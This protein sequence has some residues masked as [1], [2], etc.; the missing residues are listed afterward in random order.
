LPLSSSFE[1]DYGAAVSA[2]CATRSASFQMVVM[3][4]GLRVAIEAAG[5]AGDVSGSAPTGRCLWAG[6][7][8]QALVFHSIRAAGCVRVAEVD[9][10][11]GGDGEDC[12]AG[13]SFP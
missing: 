4:Q 11:A 5:N 3:I 7:G 1:P 10:N 8:E 12:V 2:V 9:R 13:H 6:T